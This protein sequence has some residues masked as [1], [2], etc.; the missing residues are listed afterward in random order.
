[1]E[2]TTIGNTDLKVSKLCL[3]GMSFGNSKWM[4]DEENSIKII[5]KAIDYGINYIDTANIYSGGK[6]EEIIGKAIDGY[7]D[8][9]I[10]STKGAGKMNDFYYGFNNKYLNKAINDSLKRLKT[11]YIDIYYLHTMLDNVDMESTLKLLD[12]NIKNNKIDYLGASNFSG[13]QLA[14]FFTISDKLF[15]NRIEI[16]QNHYNAVYRE[17]E[18]EVIPFCKKKNI[19]YSPFSPLAAGFLSGKYKRNENNESTRTESYPVMKK[20]YFKDYD[21]DVLDNIIEISRE[22]GVKPVNI[23]LAYIIK[24][25]FLPVIGV[26]KPEY[27]E[28]NINSLDVNLN[29]DDMGRID[30]RYVP[31]NII[32]GTAGY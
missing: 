29:D 32:K 23:A 4:A 31:H 28:D 27:F 20:R 3:G 16:V 30:E 25:G 14:E 24:K 22:K 9:L 15:N 19:T 8:N 13:Y 6:S 10:I 21:F 26:N 2:Y 1:M 7:R 17:D 12:N 18:R 5:K 11:D